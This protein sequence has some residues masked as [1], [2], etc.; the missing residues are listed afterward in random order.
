MTNPFVLLRTE[1]FLGH[2]TLLKPGLLVTLIALYD[3]VIFFAY[4]C[5]D[6]V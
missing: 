3:T 2:K 5:F 1:D 6:T 4:H